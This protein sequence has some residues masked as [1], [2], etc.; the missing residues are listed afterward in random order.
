MMLAVAML[1]D[2][3]GAKKI[4]FLETT[5]QNDP[6]DKFLER[7]GWDMKALAA[8]KTPVEYEDTHNLGTGKKYVEVK[9]P[10]GGYAF[11]AYHLNH[12]YVDCDVFVSLSKLKNHGATGVTM[13][14][15]EQFRYHAHR[16]LRPA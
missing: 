2:R 7:A 10:W 16:A 1:L 5:Y 9:V 14:N 11:P 8:L 13:A 3:A 12:S 6:M 15:Q 4:R